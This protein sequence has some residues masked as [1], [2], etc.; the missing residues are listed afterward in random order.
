[1]KT[2]IYSDVN[3]LKITGLSTYTTY[4]VTVSA[5]SGGGNGVKSGKLYVGK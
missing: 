3:G 4:K 1:M 2:I 5:L